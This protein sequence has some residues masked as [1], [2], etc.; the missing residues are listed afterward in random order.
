MNLVNILLS[1]KIHEGQ[2]LNEFFSRVLSKLK[3]REKGKFKKILAYLK[4]AN[5]YSWLKVYE[6]Q[7]GFAFE[8]LVDK[9]YY[10][11]FFK[12]EKLD[13]LLREMLVELAAV[14]GRFMNESF[15]PPYSYLKKKPDLKEFG[16]TVLPKRYFKNEELKKI[17]E[18]IKAYS[19][20]VLP[21]ILASMIEIKG[22]FD[23]NKLERNKRYRRIKNHLVK[24]G[25]ITEDSKLLTSL[26]EIEE[27]LEKF[28]NPHPVCLICGKP[29]SKPGR[30]VCS[31]SKDNRS[32]SD[33]K[34]HARQWLKNQIK[35]NPN[36]TLDEA[37]KLFIGKEIKEA[38]KAKEKRKK[39]KDKEWFWSHIKVK[40]PQEL[41][42]RLWLEL[43]NRHIKK[44]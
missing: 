44:G 7:E 23:L 8:C 3:G 33:K 42:K 43:D 4:M 38:K 6:F 9:F 37:I 5:L 15:S 13:E 20:L 28:L 35:K 17:E 16:I 10:P 2:D 24:T 19:Y 32:C 27:E 36:L 26:P 22:I 14:V 11:Y 39:Y 18:K 12:N 31:V 30:Y 25:H 41:I 21:F 1:K 40:Y 29:L 34:G